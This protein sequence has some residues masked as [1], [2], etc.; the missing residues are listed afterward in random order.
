M[1]SEE[2][3]SGAVSFGHV[4]F[5]DRVQTLSEDFDI[6]SAAENVATNSGHHDPITVALDDWLHSEGH[7]ENLVGYYTATGVGVAQDDTGAYYF[8][9]IYVLLKD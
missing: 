8:T 6:V 5:L 7:H 4:G 2:M 3:A 9:Q 1:H